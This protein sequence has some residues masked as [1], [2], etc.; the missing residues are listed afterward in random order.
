MSGSFK[1]DLPAQWEVSDTFLF[2]CILL[3]SR[4]PCKWKWLQARGWLLSSI[5]SP[6]RPEVNSHVGLITCPVSAAQRGYEMANG[7]VI[8]GEEDETRHNAPPFRDS[9]LAGVFIV[10]VCLC[11]SEW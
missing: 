1:Q 7:F 10:Y 5:V 4:S 9:G 2:L 6:D 11:P 8:P 3:A